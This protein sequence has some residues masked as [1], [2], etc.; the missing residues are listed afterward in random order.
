[1]FF[2]FCFFSRPPP[3]PG[4]GRKKEIHS[5]VYQLC[6]NRTEEASYRHIKAI[7]SHHIPFVRHIIPGI[8]PVCCLVVHCIIV[9]LTGLQYSYMCSQFSIYSLTVVR[10]SQ[11][12]HDALCEHRV[13]LAFFSTVAY[14]TMYMYRNRKEAV[15]Q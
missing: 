12:F 14:R 9:W 4:R 1:M 5:F 11:A 3:P 15:C 10:P 7:T 2:C 6:D 13:I 8:G